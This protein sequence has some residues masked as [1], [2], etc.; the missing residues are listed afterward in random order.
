MPQALKDGVLTGSVLHEW[1]IQEYERH[2][3]GWLWYLIIGGLGLLMVF[4]GMAT[5]NFLF[6]LI[7]ILAAIV[8]FIQSNQ[9]PLQVPFQITELGAVVGNKF[10]PYGE[11]DSFYVIYNPPHVKTLYL[12]TKGIIHPTLRIALLDADPMEVKQTLREFLV[13]D[14]E[15]EEEPLADRAARNWR[16]H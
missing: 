5:G 1:T 13:E 3:R 2:E 4:Y 12:V 14:T 9:E 8:I 16:L 10:Y 11:F 7:V 6:S 15:K